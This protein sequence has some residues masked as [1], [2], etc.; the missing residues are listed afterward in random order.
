MKKLS[1]FHTPF[2]FWVYFKLVSGFYNMISSIHIR[3]CYDDVR[4]HPC[5]HL[6]DSSCKDEQL[7][8]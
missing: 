8:S 7:L 3:H 4:I 6:P 1:F 2:L 5:S